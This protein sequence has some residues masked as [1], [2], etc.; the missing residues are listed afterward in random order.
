MLPTRALPSLL[1]CRLKPGYILAL[2][3]ALA[4]PCA[5]AWCDSAMAADDAGPGAWR[6]SGFGTLGVVHADTDTA[7]FTSSVLKASGAGATRRWSMDVDTRLGAQ[8]DFAIAPQ[9]SAVLQVVSEQRYDNSYRPNVEWANVKYQVTPDVSVRVGRMALPVFMAAEHRKIGYVYSMVRQPTEVEGGVPITSSD[10]ID[11]SWRWNTGALR[12]TTRLQYGRTNMALDAGTRL[13]ANGIAAVSH[14]IDAGA[15]SVRASAIGAGVTVNLADQLFG[16]LKQFGPAGV[17][18][19]DQYSVDHKRISLVA[20][21]MEYD[22]GD[23]FVTIEGGRQ[24]SQSM[25][26]TNIGLALG[27]G[28]R[29]RAF[30]PYVGYSDVRAQA[31]TASRGLSTAGLPAQLAYAASALNAG[32]NQL[33]ITLPEQSTASIGT[34]W[35][36]HENMALKLQVDSVTPHRNSRGTLINTQPGFTSGRTVCVTSMSLDFVF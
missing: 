2:A 34:R 1:L 3:L 28:Y 26:G 32:L 6:F 15:F 20:L 12:H 14:S 7:D 17:A 36:V 22:P 16:A 30:T 11:L 13:R 8:V 33:L 31:S 23:W 27:A 29:W 18:L 19:A 24:R 25:L 4:L 35:D 21:G 9:W 5:P 10:G